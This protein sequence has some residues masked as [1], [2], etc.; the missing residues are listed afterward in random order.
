V[1]LEFQGAERVRDMLYGVGLAMSEIVG[2]V[3]APLRPGARVRRVQD[4][5]QNGIA[6]VHVA[7]SKVDLCAQHAGAV[8]KLAAAHIAKQA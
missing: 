1:V 3:D 7:G 4:A 8:R 5:I 6:Q 2:R